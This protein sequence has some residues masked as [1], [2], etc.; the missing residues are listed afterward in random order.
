MCV[1]VSNLSQSTP[2]PPGSPVDNHCDLNALEAVMNKDHDEAH[3]TPSPSYSSGCQA[4]YYTDRR[5]G[6]T[7]PCPNGFFCPD[8]QVCYVVCALGGSC[9][10][11]HLDY[12]GVTTHWNGNESITQGLPSCRYPR[13]TE[14]AKGY[15]GTLPC[16]GATSLSLCP[17]GS[18]CYNPI[19][20]DKCPPG[21]YCALGSPEPSKCPAIAQCEEE[22]LTAPKY[23]PTM[24]RGVVI[25]FAVLIV[26]YLT[27]GLLRDTLRKKRASAV[28]MPPQADASEGEGDGDSSRPT[29][30]VP[31][32]THNFDI[33]KADPRMDIEF[34]ALGLKLHGDGH[35]VLNGVT[36][37]FTSGRVA[38]IMGPS[39]V[40]KTTF[41]N[42]LC[43]RATYGEMTGKVRAIYRLSISAPRTLGV[44]ATLIVCPSVAFPAQ[45]LINKREDKIRNY[46]HLVGL[47][48]QDDVM[49]PWL[50][51]KEN[52]WIYA[53]LRQRRDRSRRATVEAKVN[54]IMQRLG[55]YAQRHSIIGDAR[56]RGISGG[57]RKRVNVAMELVL[58][59]SVLLLDEPT[60]GLDSSTS[61][62]LV[63]ALR[64][65]ADKGG[66]STS[67]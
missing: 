54:Q 44:Y 66:V 9:N 18:Y 6:Q 49:H 63:D 38:A 58:D 4:G 45:V 36:G 5:T 46:T 20:K 29:S 14:K 27:T 56:N 47:V 28:S 53:K 67:A 24:T 2:F 43:G 17:S 21:F 8:G 41:L 42:T 10:A 65:F 32:S 7:K 40:G 52:L 11:S 15:D 64:G 26:G 35:R 12:S 33:L 31:P 51:V 16:P 55:L 13:G 48:P 19:M 37:K 30:P 23:S 50:S 62:E 3:C 34:Q 60:S 59:P 1:G 22:G 25:I 39:G 61:F 57:Q